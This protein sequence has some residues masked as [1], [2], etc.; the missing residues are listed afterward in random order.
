MFPVSFEEFIATF[1]MF[2]YCANWE[3]EIISPQVLEWLQKAFDIYFLVGRYPLAVV[4]FLDGVTLGEVAEIHQQILDM[5]FSELRV[6]MASLGDYAKL[7]SALFSIVD[8]MMREKN[9][10]NLLIEHLSNFMDSVRPLV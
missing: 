2:E 8:L 9:G 6:R 10:D 5:L 4:S 1:S 3:N 7:N